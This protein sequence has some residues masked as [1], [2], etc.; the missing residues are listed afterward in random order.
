M[1]GQ[2][3]D[4]KSF[5][6]EAFGSYI[7]TIP[8]VNKNELIKSRTI[9][10]NARIKDLLSSQTGS[11]YGTIPFFGRIGGEAQ[12]YDGKTDIEATG[13]DTYEQSVIAIG[14][15]SAW[16]EKDFSTDI[17]A[18]VDFMSEVAR[19]VAEYWDEIDTGILMSILKGIFSMTTTDK[20][21]VLKHT[22]NIANDAANYRM[23]PA[24]LNSAIQK[25]CGDKRGKFRLVFM[26]SAVATNL[27]NQNLLEFLK[28]TDSNG[29]QRPLPLASWNGRTVIVDDGMPYMEAYYEATAD[30]PGALL[31]KTS[32]ATAGQINI[33]DVTP[34]VG[35]TADAPADGMYVVKDVQYVTYVFGEGA[36]HFADLG[37]KVPYEMSR[38]P[39]TNGGEDTLYSRRRMCYAPYGISFTKKSVA[40]LSPTNAEL[41][42]GENW[43]LIDNGQTSGKRK[44]IDHRDI[45]IAQ[46]ISRG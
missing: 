21:F 24:T 9:V 36:F 19:Q 26:H 17:T 32:G 6:P 30:D 3:F 43:K 25:A 34:F 8:Q 33:S 1:A 5:N 20:D 16:T 14:R 35:H 23:G 37:A 10:S 41:E 22:Y 45:A 31:V 13:M 2:K 12:N 40:S 38:D 29:I 11:F 46:I 4:S 27:E 44:V 28:Y 18:G 7:E 42:K 39:K 15:A